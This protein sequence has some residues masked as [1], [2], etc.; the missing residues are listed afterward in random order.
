MKNLRIRFRRLTLDGSGANGSGARTWVTDRARRGAFAAAAA[1]SI[2]LGTMVL[3]HAVEAQWSTVYPSGSALLSAPCLDNTVTLSVEESRLGNTLADNSNPAVL[4]T[5]SFAR[6][7]IEGAG[8]EEF[9]PSLVNAVCKQRNLEE[10]REFLS[11][12][13]QRLWRKAVDRAQQHGPVKGSLPYSDDRPLYWTRLQ[14]TAALHLAR[15][16]RHQLPGR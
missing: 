13:A 14:I 1:L 10:T 8:F 5:T 16:V 11:E 4:Q 7:M 12:R 6:Q 15:H 3:A 9:G 2:A